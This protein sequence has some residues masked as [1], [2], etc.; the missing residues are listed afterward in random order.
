MPERMARFEREAQLLASLNHPTIAAIYGLEESNGIRALVM[1]RVEGETLA[2][3]I[4]GEGS[5][6]PRER[7][8]LP[9]QSI[10]SA[11]G[12]PSAPWR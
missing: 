1:E 9:Y 3:K 10:L 6:L 8:A 5:A 7:A 11:S 4:V 2:E 12:L